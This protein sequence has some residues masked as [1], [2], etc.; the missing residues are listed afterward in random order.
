MTFFQQ[1]TGINAIGEC[2]AGTGFPFPANSGH[3]P[4]LIRH[5]QC[6]MLPRSFLRWV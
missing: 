6:T 2:N 3:S 1:F 5:A 4:K